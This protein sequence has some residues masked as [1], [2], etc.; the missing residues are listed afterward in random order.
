VSAELAAGL[1]AACVRHFGP[2]TSV[3]NLDVLTGGASRQT[4]SFDAVLAGGRSEGLVLRRDPP[5]IGDP[6]P[7]ADQRTLAADRATEFAV[8]RAMFAAGVTVPEPLFLLTPA[9]DLGDGFVMRRRP[10]IAIARK[11]LRD[12]EYAAA[13]PRIVGQLGAEL[14]KIH[15]ADPASL[16]PL[17]VCTAADHIAMLRRTLDAIGQPS[18]VFELALAWLERHLP[19][20]AP[21]RPLHGDFRTGNFL[22]DAD[23]L[24]AILDWEAPHI[25]DPLSDLGWFCVK[26]WRFGEIGRPAGGFGSREEL[27]AAYGAAG[28]EPVDPVRARFWEVL[29]TVRWGVICLVQ[30]DKHLSG[31]QRSMELCAIGRRAAETEYDIVELFRSG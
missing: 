17:P 10:G 25:G 30:A 18:P 31:V 13:R 24:T 8:L 26:S 22:A 21:L 28:G 16:P 11:L 7:T 27:W 6:P 9:D 15:R 2:K 19:A 4:V 14:A 20:D 3:G 1:T 29:G 23:G 5:R 12:A